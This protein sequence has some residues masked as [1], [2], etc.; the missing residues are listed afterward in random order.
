MEPSEAEIV[1][2]ALSDVYRIDAVQPMVDRI[3]HHVAQIGPYR[4]VLI[5]LYFGPDVYIGME[6]GEEAL[7]E[8]FREVARKTPHAARARKRARIWERY[9]IA[10]TNICFIPQGSPI[11]FSPSFLPSE[12]VPGQEWRSEDRLMVFVRGMDGEVHGVLSLDR[13]ADGQRPDPEHLGSLAAIDRFITHMGVLV[14]NRHL[15]AKL[16]ESEER[17][18]AVVEQ[19]HDAIL[20]VRDGSVLFVNHRLAEMLGAEPAAFFGRPVDEVV[21]RDPGGA[22]PGEQEGR[23]IGPDNRQV[24]VALRSGTIRFGAADATLIA[25]A[26]ISERKRLFTHLVRAQK[27]ESIGTLASGIAHDFNNLLGGILGYTSLMRAHLAPDHPAAR[28]LGSIER[29][30]DR[31]A[32]VTRQ[33]LGIVRGEKIEVG[34]FPVCRVLGEVAGL[35]EETFDPSIEVTVRCDTSMPPVIGDEGQIHQVLLNVCINSRDAMPNGGR[36]VLEGREGGRLSNGRRC[37]KI[38]IHDDGIGMDPE[39][40]SKVFDPFFTTKQGGQ[41]TG[42]GLYMAYRVVERHKGSMDIAS[43]PGSGT[44]VEILLPAGPG[45]PLP[46]GA[47]AGRGE[48]GGGGAVLLV[49]DEELI[50]GVAAEMLERLGYEPVC[51]S[52]GGEAVEIVRRRPGRF[53]CVLLDIAMPVMNGWQAAEEIR[54]LDPAL[55]ILFSSGHDVEAALGD[56]KGIGAAHSLKKPYRMEELRAA[57]AGIRRGSTR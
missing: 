48:V 32:E 10:D 31:A 17:Y 36:L 50:R 19:G 6:G 46:E 21:S 11:T 35:L 28:Y 24:D 9:R 29:A 42:L 25:A 33:L 39:T 2:A 45:G 3:C 12:E 55:P 8:R 20:I 37:V 44:T 56:M 30:A 47:S 57:L 52:D 34:A 43:S 54:K 38:T 7:R 23:L 51:A 40:A 53:L 15:A 1:L 49:D 18:A 22:L 14:H 27:M 13:P 26:D 16:R 5:S 41:G 4:L